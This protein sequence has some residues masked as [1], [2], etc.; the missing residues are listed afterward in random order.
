MGKKA[1]L[2]KTTISESQ[3]ASEPQDVPQVK[4]KKVLK[5]DKVGNASGLDLKPKLVK[6]GKKR[7]EVSQVAE[8]ADDDREP[9][10]NGDPVEEQ[11]QPQVEEGLFRKDS[12]FAKLG[13]AKW[14]IESCQQMGMHYPTEIQVQSIPHILAGKHVAGNAKTGSGKTACYCLPTLHRLSQDPYGVFTL[15]LTP[16]R[17]LAFQVSENFRALG[18]AIKVSVVEVVGGR[19]MLAQSAMISERRHVV[20]ATPGRL[21]DLLQGDMKIARAFNKLQILVLDEADRMLQPTFEEPLGQVLSAIPKER[22]T[23][24]FSATVTKTIEALGDR[25]KAQGKELLFIDANPGDDQ[26][27]RLKQQYIFVPETVRLC[28]LFYLLQNDFAEESCMIFTPTIDTC[29]LLATMLDVCKISA[30]CLHSLQN[31][32][33]RLAGLSKF[34]AGRCKVLVAT[35]V[36]GRG[37]DIPLVAVVINLGLPQSADEY[38]HRAGRTARAGR[39]GRVVSLVTQNDVP[40]VHL[41]EERIGRQL[42]LYHVPEEAA[43]KMLSKT[44]K[45]QQKAELLLYEVGFDDKVEEHRLQ[46]KRQQSSTPRSKRTKAALDPQL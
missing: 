37:L 42:E 32:R 24:L 41:V 31:Q 10:E 11:P 14:L 26:L 3:E 2:R 18:T 33:R 23:L 44:A 4:K 7:K 27:Q 6:K 9:E 28:Y 20:V 22:Q 35:D 19:E 45:V 1:K 12:S 25:L 36:A 21:A 40:R 38:V 46:R 39:P 15:V 16:V 29:Q 17:E 43:L 34:R 5:K 13:L 30:T 8:N